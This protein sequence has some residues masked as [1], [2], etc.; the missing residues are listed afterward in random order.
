MISGV[1]TQVHV[2]LGFTYYR[3]AVRTVDPGQPGCYVASEQVNH[4][5]VPTDLYQV[6]DMEPY[7]EQPLQLNVLDSLGTNLPRPV[8]PT[9]ELCQLMIPTGVGGIDGQET[10]DLLNTVARQGEPFRI[11]TQAAGLINV[12][13]AEGRTVVHDQRYTGGTAIHTHGWAPGLYVLCVS[14]QDGSAVRTYRVVVTP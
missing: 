13:D 3:P 1:L 7:L 9:L 14:G 8:L 2:D 12:L 11:A 10:N 5:P 4:I 6:E